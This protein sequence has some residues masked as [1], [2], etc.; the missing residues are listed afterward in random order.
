MKLFLHGWATSPRTE[1]NKKF[2][3]EVV[4][5]W[6]NKILIFPFA[7][8][9]RDYDLQFELDSQKFIDHNPHVDI[10][11]AMASEDI[12]VLIKQI[13]EYNSLYFCGWRMGYHL[14]IVK[15]IWNLKELFDGKIIS[16]NSSWSL[17]WCKYAYDQDIETTFKIWLGLLNVKM[18]THWWTDRYP[19]KTDEDRLEELRN[20]WEALPIYKIR[21]QEY[22][23]FEL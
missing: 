15:Q 9:N 7:Q 10:E 23:V 8:K 16:G 19:D 4:K 3:Q 11:C 18:I 12:E 14:D 17:M 21:E 1:K 6:W 2:F 20:Y 13:K 5:V 22:E